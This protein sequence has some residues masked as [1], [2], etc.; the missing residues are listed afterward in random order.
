MNCKKEI[1]QIELEKIKQN[2]KEVDAS[3]N[4]MIFYVDTL[5]SDYGSSV[6]E[7]LEYVE[8]E[9]NYNKAE[10]LGTDD[11]SNIYLLKR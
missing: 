5:V 8:K 2:I 7:C 9:L 4:E 10:L 3:E 6:D 11:M 1:Y